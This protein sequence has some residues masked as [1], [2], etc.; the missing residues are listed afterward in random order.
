MKF[1]AIQGKFNKTFVKI[2]I[3]S[4]G[5]KSFVKVIKKCLYR[6]EY[7]PF[8]STF[9]RTVSYSYFYEDQYFPS[10][11]W[12]DVAK[13]YELMYKVPPTLINGDIIRYPIDDF[14]LWLG[15]LHLPEAYV[16]GTKV[17]DDG[18]VRDYTFQTE[19]TKAAL[20]NV[21]GRI[22]IG[23]S[24]GK[25]LI[26]YMYCRYLLEHPSSNVNKILIFV[27]NKSLCIQLSK[28]F[29]EY[30]SLRDD[31]L[32]IETIYSASKKV[33]QA[34]IVVGTY[35]SIREYEPDYFDEFGAIICDEAHTSKAYSIKQG[36]FQKVRN[37]R[38]FFG[39]SGTYP[40]YKSLDYLH[41]TSMFGTCVYS[42]S[43]MSLVDD[44][45][46]SPMYIYKI[47][48]N[49]LDPLVKNLS[50][51]LKAEGIIG[52]DKY[53]Q[54]KAFLQTHKLRL[55]LIVKFVEK[56]DGNSLVLVDTLEYADLLFDSI[57]KT[58]AL[59][60]GEKSKTKIVNYDVIEYQVESRECIYDRM[61]N[62]TNF[63]IVAT[64]GTMSTGISINN[65]TN[66]FF[67]DGGKSFIR[68]RQSIG[69]SLRLHPDKE[70]ARIF[71][72]QDNIPYSSFRNH[73]MARNKIYKEQKFPII[74]RQISL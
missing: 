5:D 58:S 53:R 26:T 45:V 42:K 24:G 68:I 2:I 37:A 28:D 48:I 7:S 18:E 4:P 29:D 32:I 8:K 10:S 21:V 46:S 50:I 41:I 73:A 31:K 34:N 72:F 13:Q 62:D 56:I 57:N 12:D 65:L 15:E 59:I 14:D 49:Y 3:E 33:D 6:K 35:H 61:R 19:A 55:E 30:Q 23:T 1:E 64:F 74:E 69:R 22:E 52:T 66:I 47:V 36:I 60:T 20:H 71:D 54:E 63:V 9:S 40:D 43:T 16:V 25:T 39:M 51:D 44:N 70:R 38:F 67:P 17:A 11:F 27:P